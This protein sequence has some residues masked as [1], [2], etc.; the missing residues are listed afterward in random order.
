MNKTIIALI[1]LGLS[2]TTVF[3][4]KGDSDPKSLA[5]SPFMTKPTAS[6]MPAP[7]P[8]VKPSAALRLARYWGKKHG[9]TTTEIEEQADAIKEAVA[10]TR[11]PDHEGFV[12]P[13]KWDFKF[14]ILGVPKLSKR[15]AV[16]MRSSQPAPENI[17]EIVQAAKRNDIE[18]SEIYLLNLR[19]EN[20]V[21]ASYVRDFAESRISEEKNASQVTTGNLRILDHTIPRA[22][23]VLQV[24]RILT[25]PKYKLVVL[26]CKVGKARTGIMV[27]IQRVVLDGW[28]VEE[29]LEEA[30][31][32][33]LRRPLQKAF[34]RQFV[35]DFKAGKHKL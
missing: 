13:A 4:A 1:A 17:I 22:E 20:N 30:E 27:A 16:I 21:E 33:G 26:H 7:A 3:A 15:R 32:R 9:L 6:E 35:A 5:K 34:V 18:P 19:A 28:T 25:D 29:A 24:L 2:G 31:S 10:R 11:G 14:K 8:K 23:Q 12:I